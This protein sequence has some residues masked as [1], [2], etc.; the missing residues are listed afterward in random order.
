MDPAL[1][2]LRTPLST[3]PRQRLD[4]HEDH[5]T[6]TSTE[7]AL[8]ALNIRDHQ[9]VKTSGVALHHLDVAG[10]TLPTEEPPIPVGIAVLHIDDHQCS[11]GKVNVHTGSFSYRLRNASKGAQTRRFSALRVRRTCSSE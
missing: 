4:A 2:V 1:F 9:I 7:G 10:S 6:T 8:Q 3:V 11:G 5:L